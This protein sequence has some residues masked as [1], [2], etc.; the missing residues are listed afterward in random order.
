LTVDDFF[1]AD[2]ADVFDS[3]EAADGINYRYLSFFIIQ[4]RL[5]FF[6]SSKLSL[7]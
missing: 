6:V 3:I 5:S 4:I 2:N 7:T 1:N